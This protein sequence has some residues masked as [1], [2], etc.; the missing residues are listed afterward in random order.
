VSDE[1]VED[2]IYRASAGPQLEVLRHHAAGL[3]EVT[4]RIEIEASMLA[5]LGVSPGDV[6]RAC[7]AWLNSRRVV[8]DWAYIR[9]VLFV[10]E[11]DRRE[12]EEE[13]R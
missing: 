1:E 2:M 4:P 5:E 10:R 6:A 8:D 12:R 3:F 7:D 11:A 9:T 13:D